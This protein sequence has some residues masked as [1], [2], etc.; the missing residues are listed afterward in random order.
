MDE[1]GLQPDH[2]MLHAV[3]RALAGGSSTN[4]LISASNSAAGGIA[5]PAAN[6]RS[7]SITLEEHLGSDK[8]DFSRTQSSGA[9][10]SHPTTV[11][12]PVAKAGNAAGELMAVNKHKTIS[13]AEVWN[14]ENWRSLQKDGQSRCLLKTL[15]VFDFSDGCTV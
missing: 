12:A 14:F 10:L 3:V 2:L 5:K 4:A 9:V 7:S 15:L 13:P 6:Q 8:V 11:G 1:Q